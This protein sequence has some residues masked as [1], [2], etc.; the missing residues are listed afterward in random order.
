MKKKISK[1]K[2]KTSKIEAD[3][4]SLQR[5]AD[6]PIRDIK[7]MGVALY[8]KFSGITPSMYL[9]DIAEYSDPNIEDYQKRIKLCRKLRKYEGICSTVA[10]LLA[11][12]AITDGC[13]DCKD[14]ELKDILNHWNDWANKIDEVSDDTITTSGIRC[15]A[16]K[17]FDDW[18][19]DGD[20]VFIEYWGVNKK[21]KIP[22]MTKTYTLPLNL[23]GLDVLQLNIPE[24]LAKYGIERIYLNV[25]NELKQVIKNPKTEDQKFLAKTI[26]QHWKKHIND[27]SGI[28]LDPI[29]VHHIKRN[30]KD[31]SARGE[32]YF[33][34][35]FSAIVNKRRI[36][37]LDAST[38]QGLINRL[39]IIKIG[40]ANKELNPAYHVPSK[41][42]VSSLVAMLEDPKRANLMVW[43]GPDLEVLDIG[44]QG[45][46][47]EIDSRYN[48]ADKDILRALH[49]SPLLIDGSGAGASARNWAALISTIV[50]LDTFRSQFITEINHIARRIAQLNG[51][52]ESPKYRFKTQLLTDETALKK[53][54]LQL[55]ELGGISIETLVT[56]SGYDFE[57]EKRRKQKEQDEGVPE[58]FITKTIPYQGRPQGG[59]A[60]ANINWIAETNTNDII[61]KNLSKY[62]ADLNRIYDSV[63][64]SVKEAII[65]KKESKEVVAILV[66]SFIAFRLLVDKVLKESFAEQ[67]GSSGKPERWFTVMNNWNAGYI[68]NFL[69]DL[70]NGV[71]EAITKDNAIDLVDILFE[72]YRY[73]V[74]MY[75]SEGSRKALWLGFLASNEES[76][77]RMGRWVC[78]FVNSCSECMNNHGSILSIDDLAAKYPVHPNE[79]CDIEMLK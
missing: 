62:G 53:F 64:T 59:S 7:A 79:Q 73:R 61:E 9:S 45:K 67:F 50:G 25:D 26:P 3:L 69:E 11:D 55:Y 8:K 78:H 51:F 2:T 56:E 47:L 39:T 24:S 12:F 46:I 23:K 68:N 38:I 19:T 48:Q 43:P 4:M 20:A 14:Q 16:R 15:F 63:R 35:C 58:L 70:K 65:D 6:E 36:Q 66:S 71:G 72:T 40:M 41:G 37:A 21:V 49:V 29:T 22:G 27:K 33:V 17:V 34:K 42:R 60:K 76:G 77:Y 57:A 74:N 75:I 1:T 5:I 31:Y 52:D 30:G 13:F 44:A 54:I 10:D 32:S 28:P 18:L